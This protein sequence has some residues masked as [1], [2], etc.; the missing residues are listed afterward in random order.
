MGTQQAEIDGAAFNISEPLLDIFIP[1]KPNGAAA[2]VVGGGG[3]RRI[4][5]VKEAYPAAGWLTDIGVTAFVLT[6]RLP[7]EGWA[8]G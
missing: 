4:G 6:Y 1:P 7:N 8:D 3:Y 5:L 2:L